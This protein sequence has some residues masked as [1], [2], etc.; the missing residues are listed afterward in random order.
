MRTAAKTSIPATVAT[1]RT[2]TLASPKKNT[3]EVPILNPASTYRRPEKNRM[4]KYSS[5]DDPVKTIFDA[6]QAFELTPEAWLAMQSDRKARE[7]GPRA[8]TH[9]SQVTESPGPVDE[10][11][12]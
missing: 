12:N 10:A 9:K 1:C 2:N 4:H 6:D 5:E 8:G 3:T 7:S 11:R